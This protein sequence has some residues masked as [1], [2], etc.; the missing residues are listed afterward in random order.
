VIFDSPNFSQGSISNAST[1]TVEHNQVGKSSPS[2]TISAIDN[3]VVAIRNC[4]NRVFS[5]ADKVTIVSDPNHALW[6]IGVA[7]KFNR[8]YKIPD[9]GSPKVLEEL[10]N[11]IA[12]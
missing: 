9:S 12:L 11:F 5:S 1:A 8:V 3:S 6:L 4:R 7:F 10:Y 2:S